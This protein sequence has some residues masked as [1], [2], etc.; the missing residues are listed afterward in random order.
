VNPIVS[1]IIKLLTLAENQK[2]QPEGE[3]AAKLAHKMMIAHAVS[4]ADLSDQEIADSDPLEK[5]SQKV[6]VSMWRRLLYTALAY[7]CQLRV[8]Y[9]SNQYNGQKIYLYGHRSDIEVCK[10]LYEICER[11]ILKAARAYVSDL[12]EYDWEDS[13]LYYETRSLRGYKKMAGNNFRRSAIAG[14]RTKLA[15]IRST[16]EEENPTGFALVINRRKRVSDW[17][18]DK[19]SF[20]KG[21]DNSSY[22]HSRAGYR[23]GRDVNLSAG[24]SK[25]KPEIGG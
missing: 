17:V 23:A 24:A 21:R 25:P 6:P 1:K 13:E 15:E 3:L 4:Q 9:R 11:Q 10:Y 7:H 20:K 5:Q 12:D 14:L 22:S 19:Y 16:G 18:D 8:A 2:G